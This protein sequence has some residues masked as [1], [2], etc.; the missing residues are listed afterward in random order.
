MGGNS[1]VAFDD[2]SDVML[3]NAD[4]TG[5]VN[6]TNNAARD[7]SPAFSHDGSKIAFISNRSGSDQV[8]I[9]N[10]DGSAP[11]QVTTTGAGSVSF[12]LTDR[13]LVYENNGGSDG[14][15]YTMMTIGVDGSGKMKVT[16]TPN[17][18]GPFSVYAE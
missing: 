14:A 1:K 4:G 3:V 12:D 11:Q 8:W 13:Y 9:M 17:G 6:L 7:R 16:P 2:R 15:D 5:L 18:V 10:A